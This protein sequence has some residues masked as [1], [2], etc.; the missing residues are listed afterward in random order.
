MWDHWSASRSCLRVRRGPKGHDTA[1]PPILSRG[2][3]HMVPFF[4][5]LV[6]AWC[7]ASFNRYAEPPPR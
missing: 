1:C 6:C 5:E 7:A 3:A 2:A 4:A